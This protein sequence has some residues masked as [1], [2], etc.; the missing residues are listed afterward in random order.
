[1]KTSEVLLFGAFVFC[2]ALATL[3]GASQ[4]IVAA[5]ATAALLFGCCEE[6]CPRRGHMPGKRKSSIVADDMAFVHKQIQLWQWFWLLI[7][8]TALFTASFTVLVALNE[9]WPGT[10]IRWYGIAAPKAVLSLGVSGVL[11]LYG[12]TI[13]V[14]CIQPLKAALHEFSN[15]YRCCVTAEQNSGTRGAGWVADNQ[16]D[17][18]DPAAMVR[19]QT[20]RNRRLFGD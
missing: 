4:L 5:G 14:G 8:A 18:N 1:M 11:L 19:L 20:E 6:S 7:A 2:V 13:A 16:L 9:G 17:W 10:T 15:E 3:T 12:I